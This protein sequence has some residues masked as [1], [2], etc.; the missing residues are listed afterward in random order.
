MDRE[1]IVQTFNLIE[2]AQ[3]LRIHPDTL[4]RRAAAGEI[5]GA[6][7]GKCWVFVDVD[8]VEWL[9][10]SY[11]TAPTSS[12]VEPRTFTESALDRQRYPVTDEELFSLLSPTKKSDSGKRATKKREK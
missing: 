9:R 12:F 2:A 7:P 4:Q 1:W 5:P 8:L 6:K 3:F 10:K 11:K